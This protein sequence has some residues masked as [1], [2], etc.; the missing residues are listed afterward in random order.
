MKRAGKRRRQGVKDYKQVR[1]DSWLYSLCG[2]DDQRFDFH[3]SWRFMRHTCNRT[4]VT[5]P[6]TINHRSVFHSDSFPHSP[7]LQLSYGKKDRRRHINDQYGE[8]EKHGGRMRMRMNIGK[9]GPKSYGRFKGKRQNGIRVRIILDA[10]SFPITDYWC[11]RGFRHGM[12]A[13][14]PDIF[15]AQPCTCRENFLIMVHHD[16]VHAWS[17]LSPPH[18]PN[19]KLVGLLPIQCPPSRYHHWSPPKA[20]CVMLLLYFAPSKLSQVSHLFSAARKSFQSL[21]FI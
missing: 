10:P 4:V 9:N 3:K 15:P 17:F 21:R 6:A 13:P 14:I 20:I 7:A 2:W 12:A 11:I 19:R 1:K 18:Y 8:K 16:P 5:L